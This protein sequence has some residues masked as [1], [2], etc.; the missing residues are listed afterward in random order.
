[1]IK[2]KKTYFI[3]KYNPNDK[4][5]SLNLCSQ[6]KNMGHIGQPNSN[7]VADMET[8]NSNQVRLDNQRGDEK[9]INLS[10]W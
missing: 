10:V 6:F 7:P 1:M 3:K 9:S 2:E 5:L 4:F 8:I